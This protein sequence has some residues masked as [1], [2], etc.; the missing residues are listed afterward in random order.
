MFLRC[1]R[2]WSSWQPRQFL[3]FVG[4]CGLQFLSLRYSSQ[5][6]TFGLS[7]LLSV[8]GKA[9]GS[10]DWNCYFTDMPICLAVLAGWKCTVSLADMLEPRSVQFWRLGAHPVFTNDGRRIVGF[11]RNFVLRFGRFLM[12]ST[13]VVLLFL[14]CCGLLCRKQAV[15]D[16]G[17]VWW[18]TL[19]VT[20]WTQGL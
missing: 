19:W 17:T 18:N 14:F 16:G 12:Q 8:T 2:C 10:Q 5:S 9:T 15:T 20:C 13:S 11:D 6:A 4:S 3:N 1:L 7:Q